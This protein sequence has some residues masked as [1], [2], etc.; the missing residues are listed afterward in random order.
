VEL[1][2]LPRDV[3]LVGQSFRA[4]LLGSF[5]LVFALLVAHILALGNDD[6]RAIAATRLA[7][8]LVLAGVLLLQVSP[9]ASILGAIT[10]ATAPAPPAYANYLFYVAWITLAISAALSALEF[11][12]DLGEASRNIAS[13]PTYVAALCVFILLANF[14]FRARSMFDEERLKAVLPASAMPNV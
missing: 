8:T 11:V 6:R 9:A 2:V 10:M 5:V 4:R 13:I 1:S 12:T 7:L 14:G 3:Y